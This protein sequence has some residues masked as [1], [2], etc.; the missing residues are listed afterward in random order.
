MKNINDETVLANTFKDE[1]NMKRA[2][3]RIKVKKLSL[4][5]LLAF[6]LHPVG[7]AL[8]IADSP[9]MVPYISVRCIP[10]SQIFEIRTFEFLRA[11]HPDTGR[12]Q[13]ENRKITAGPYG[14]YPLENAS[15]SC[16][17][18]EDVIVTNLQKSKGG[19]FTNTAKA[20][21]E[22]NG[23]P[24]INNVLIAGSTPVDATFLYGL[25]IQQRGHHYFSQAEVAN[26]QLQRGV[27]LL[28]IAARTYDYQDIESAFD[29]YIAKVHCS[30]HYIHNSHKMLTDGDDYQFRDQSGCNRLSRTAR[31]RFIEWPTF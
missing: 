17:L 8:A 20:T 21:V 23:T 26:S 24:L 14:M 28:D 3:H 11:D 4:W 16:Q 9:E 5:V 6:F 19:R 15:I 31:R 25:L 2:S 1:L 22:M 30:N 13:L 10:E 12:V 7:Y 18:N 29:T 27:I